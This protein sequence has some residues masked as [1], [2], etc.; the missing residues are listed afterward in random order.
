MHANEENAVASELYSS[1]VTG[2]K[3]LVRTSEL[4]K[5]NRLVHCWV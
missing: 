2:L 5:S 4:R 1:S 3:C